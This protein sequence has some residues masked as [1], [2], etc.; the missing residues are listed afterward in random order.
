A[1]ATLVSSQFVD[2]PGRAAVLVPQAALVVEPS[3]RATVKPDGEEPSGVEGI[4]HVTCTVRTEAFGTVAVTLVGAFTVPTAAAP[5]PR[6]PPEKKAHT[7]AAVA[8][9]PAMK[10][11]TRTIRSQDGTARRLLSQ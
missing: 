10:P 3:D 6:P 9:E 2:V 4:T 8:A 11:A 5:L 7:V 1:E